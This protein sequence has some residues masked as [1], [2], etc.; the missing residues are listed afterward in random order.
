MTAHR[1]TN[2]LLA[3]I[4]CILLGATWHLDAPSDHNTEMAQAAAL[5]DAIK[6]E[7]AQARFTRAAA[8]ICGNAPWAQDASGAVVCQVR[9][10]RG[11]GVVL[12]RM[13]KPAGVQP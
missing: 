13:D 1:I 2:W 6:S 7:A 9:K 4:I 10:P 11:A 8:Q 5:S 12:T 3:T